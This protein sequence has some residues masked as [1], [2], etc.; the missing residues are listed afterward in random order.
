MQRVP[1]FRYTCGENAVTDLDALATSSALH[2]DFTVTDG[3]RALVVEVKR[4]VWRAQQKTIGLSDDVVRMWE[5]LDKPCKQ[6]SSTV[7]HMRSSPRFASIKSFIAVI[8]VD[9]DLLF[10]GSAFLSFG[11]DTGYFAGLGLEYVELMSVSELERS[12][13]FL[14]PGRLIDLIIA[15]WASMGHFKLLAQVVDAKIDGTTQS[16]SDWG[17]LREAEDDLFPPSSR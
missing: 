3:S 13:V 10:H 2:A 5:R 1:V 9:D 14:G 16:Y 6:C 7:S 4:S 15:R 12:L 8:C 17:F 11:R